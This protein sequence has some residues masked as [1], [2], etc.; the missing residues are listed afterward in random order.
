[1]ASYWLMKCEFDECSFEELT[2]RPE[3]MGYWRG[4]RNYEAR[5]NIRSMK[6][7]DQVLFYQSNCSDP[8]IAGIARVRGDPYPDPSAFDP[9]DKYYDP[10]SS[11]ESPRWFS[12][13]IAPI[14]FFRNYVS[15]NLLKANETF[16]DMRLVKRG[17]RLSVHSVLGEHFKEI[18]KIGRGRKV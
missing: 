2:Q 1:M 14:L 18:K 8:G 5:N 6:A 16:S 15:L 10:I 13:D 12:V 11:P 17:Q 3:K 4:V 7:G 9:A